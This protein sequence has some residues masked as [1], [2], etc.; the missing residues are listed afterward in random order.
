MPKLDLMNLT[1][2]PELNLPKPKL[3]ILKLILETL[4]NQK[5]TCL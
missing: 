4:Q 5:R 1:K 2:K 3:K